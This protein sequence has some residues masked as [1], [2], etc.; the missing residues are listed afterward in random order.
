MPHQRRTYH[1][2]Y[3]PAPALQIRFVSYSANLG[4]PRSRIP[5][6]LTVDCTDLHPPSVWLQKRFTGLDAQLSDAFF[7]RSLNEDAC[8]IALD[9]IYT[10]ANRWTAEDYEQVENEVAVGVKCTAGMHRSVAM[11]ERLADEVSAWRGVKVRV[12]HIDLRE[13]VGAMEQ[14]G[15]G[16][17]RRPWRE[18]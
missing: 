9:R 18:I 6:L 3:R 8:Q 11:V 12:Q 7:A 2:R 5:Y 4:R 14:K 10:A 15:Y 17:Y 1:R 13:A 16:P